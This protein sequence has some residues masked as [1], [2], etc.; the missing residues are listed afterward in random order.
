MAVFILV[1]HPVNLPSQTVVYFLTN[2]MVPKALVQVEAGRLHGVPTRGSEDTGF[3]VEIEFTAMLAEST[4]FNRNVLHY[5][6]VGVEFVESRN[7][8]CGGS[9]EAQ[10]KGGT[11]E[12]NDRQPHLEQAI[13]WYRS[14]MC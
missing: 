9:N 14:L 7:Q 3:G 12:L 10:N 8:S 2:L 1:L 6:W 5:L 4:R 11:S 13:S